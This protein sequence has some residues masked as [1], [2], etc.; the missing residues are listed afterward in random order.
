MGSAW[1]QNSALRRDRWIP[2]VKGFQFPGENGGGEG[3]GE[4]GENGGRGGR[5]RFFSPVTLFA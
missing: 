5:M 2:K 1:L 4:R 3:R